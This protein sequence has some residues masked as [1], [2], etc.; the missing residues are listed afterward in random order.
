MRNKKR[1]PVNVSPFSDFFF[2]SFAIFFFLSS[3]LRA[4]ASSKSAR[5]RCKGIYIQ[6]YEDI[7]IH[8]CPHTPVNVT[9]ICLVFRCSKET[10]IQEYADN[11]IHINISISISISIYV[12]TYICIYIC[13]Y[14]CTY[15]CTYMCICIYIFWSIYVYLYICIHI[16]SS[17]MKTHIVRR[18]IYCSILQY[19]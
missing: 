15:I 2:A 1:R 11:I 16:Y 17:S 12:C 4:A 5:S 7:Y 3:F 10:H 6:D 18:L 9:Y 14:I 8:T 19:E 13:I